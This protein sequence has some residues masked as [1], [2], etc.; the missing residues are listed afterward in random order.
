MRGRPTIFFAQ[1]IYFR[2][3]FLRNILPRNLLCHNLF[4]TP[5]HIYFCRGFLHPF[6][7]QI[8]LKHTLFYSL[9]HKTK[10]HKLFSTKH[11]FCI[12]LFFIRQ[13]LLY[14]KHVQK[15]IFVLPL[16]WICYIQTTSMSRWRSVE[17]EVIF[18]SLIKMFKIK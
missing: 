7:R 3:G 14:H 8:Q 10:S 17:E 16:I 11:R 1:S 5:P 6:L 9:I 2:F 12:D 18:Y 15:Y 13:I 4:I